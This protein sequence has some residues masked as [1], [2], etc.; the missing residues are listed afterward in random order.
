MPEPI[1]QRCGQLL[2]PRHLDPVAAGESACHDGGAL[3]MP[4]SQDVNESLA[5]GAFTRHQAEFIHDEEIHLHQ[6]LLDAP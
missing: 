2:I 3:A 6:A 1:Q 4:F 5:P